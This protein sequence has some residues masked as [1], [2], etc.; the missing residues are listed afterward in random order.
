MRSVSTFPGQIHIG[1]RFMDTDTEDAEHEWE[2]VSWPATFKKGH[3]VRARV[4]RP[5]GP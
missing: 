2:V 5:R 4:Q 3:E 1:D